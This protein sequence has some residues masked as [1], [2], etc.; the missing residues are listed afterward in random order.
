MEFL[1]TLISFSAIDGKEDTFPFPR[2]LI[3]GETGVGKSSVANIMLG[4]ARD[5]DVSTCAC[6]HDL[7]KIT[8]HHKKTRKIRESLFI[9]WLRWSN[10]K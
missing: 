10:F 8:Q 3:L 2:I 1:L 6:E 7:Q 5:Y 4:R 9:F